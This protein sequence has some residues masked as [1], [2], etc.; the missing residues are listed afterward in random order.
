MSQ[1]GEQGV[2]CFSLVEGREGAAGGPRYP[3][4]D[5]GAK[6]NM[7]LWKTAGLTPSPTSG[8]PQPC[9]GAAAPP[10]PACTHLHTRLCFTSC[11]WVKQVFANSSSDFVFQMLV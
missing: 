4:W 9:C 2:G 7:E 1:A 5:F 11:S 8:S 3:S 6:S 10:P